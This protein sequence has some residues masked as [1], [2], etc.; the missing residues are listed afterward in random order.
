[1]RYVC[2]D[3]GFL[4]GLYG[5]R[6]QYRVEASSHFSRL[7]GSGNNRLVI[8]WPILYESVSTRLAKNAR[9]MLRLERDWKRLGRLNRL[10]VL[11]DELYRANVIQDCFE[12]LQ[13]PPHLRRNL[14]AVDRVI[15][16]ILAD[17]RMQ[18]S[19]F[20]TFN[21]GDFADVCEQFHRELIC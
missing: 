14:S 15:R 19:A 2:V 3:S 21:P 4:I 8:P 11:P 16:N 7:F 17:P 1:M 18:I 9:G 6:D 13:T 10:K 20:V 5:D 12:Q